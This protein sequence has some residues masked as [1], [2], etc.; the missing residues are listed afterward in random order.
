MWITSLFRH[1]KRE[2]ENSFIRDVDVVLQVEK[3][4]TAPLQLWYTKA[5]GVAKRFFPSPF[6]NAKWCVN[7]FGTK[8]SKSRKIQLTWLTKKCKMK[9]RLLGRE[10]DKQVYNKFKS[11][12]T[13]D[14]PL[15][16]GCISLDIITIR[17]ARVLR[18]EMKN[19]KILRI[20]NK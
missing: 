2:T 3:T 17:S 20:R 11:P 7:L 5:N 9:W 4:Q 8:K 18:K 6:L 12:L 1:S 15:S 16:K 19:C 10:D 14:W 13:S